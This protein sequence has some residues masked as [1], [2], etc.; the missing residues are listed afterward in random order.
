[1]SDTP[2][3]DEYVDAHGVDVYEDTPVDSRAA[4]YINADFARQLERENAGLV[5]EVRQL[6]DCLAVSVAKG[7]KSSL[8]AETAERDLAAAREWIARHGRH[9]WECNTGTIKHGDACTCGLD[10]AL[11]PAQGKEEK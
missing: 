3:T 9:T 11:A 10:A 6:Q 5:E 7:L 4:S 8:D 1:M 2:R